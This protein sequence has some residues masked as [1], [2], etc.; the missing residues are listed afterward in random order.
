MN[1]DG[2]GPLPPG[3]RRGWLYRSAVWWVRLLPVVFVSLVF[4]PPGWLVLMA[5]YVGAGML[6]TLP[7]RLFAFTEWN[8]RQSELDWSIL[9]DAIDIRFW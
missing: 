5:G 2:K 1:E 8:I 3:T 4:L 7:L 6:I 9:E